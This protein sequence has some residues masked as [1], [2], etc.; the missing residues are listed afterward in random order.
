MRPWRDHFWV[1]FN[2]RNWLWLLAW[3]GVSCME[4]GGGSRSNECNV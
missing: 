1:T 2:Y 4:Y 3:F